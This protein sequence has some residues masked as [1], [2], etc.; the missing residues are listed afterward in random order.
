MSRT[1]LGQSATSRLACLGPA[2]LALGLAASGCSDDVPRAGSADT[3]ASRKVAAER[4]SNLFHL[5]RRTADVAPNRTR[6]KGM[7]GRS[8]GPPVKTQG[9]TR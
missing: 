9:Q 5:G 4:G 2:L 8:A 6:G 7:A 1:A 3:A